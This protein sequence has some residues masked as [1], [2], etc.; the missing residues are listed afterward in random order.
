[1]K[2]ATDSVDSL[3]VNGSA[4]N[5]NS[6]HKQKTNESKI[7]K[8]DQ[9]SF[10]KQNTI[11]LSEKDQKLNHT[12]I[13]SLSAQNSLDA[14]TNSFAHR[15]ERTHSNVKNS[16]H[17]S[18]KGEH[19]KSLSL[20]WK[21]TKRRH[22]SKE[23]TK[24]LS[25]NKNDGRT[26]HK[27]VNIAS[28]NKGNSNSS[29]GRFTRDYPYLYSQYEPVSRSLYSTQE[30][31]WRRNNI[32]ESPDTYNTASYD[33][34]GTS[35]NV[36][37]VTSSDLRSRLEM[38]R[39][40][41]RNLY[42]SQMLPLPLT[43]IVR[44]QNVPH[45]NR[46]AL[47]VVN[48]MLPDSPMDTV[49]SYVSLNNGIGERI[50]N[51]HLESEQVVSD[52]L[53]KANIPTGSAMSLIQ[54]N[55]NIN[56][57]GNEELVL[58]GNAR[59]STVL[60]SSINPLER[61][62]LNPIDGST[63]AL[64]GL[65]A[66]NLAKLEN[67]ASPTRNSFE[68]NRDLSNGQLVYDSTGQPFI[69]L[70]AGT[71]GQKT[72]QEQLNLAT[73]DDLSRAEGHVNGLVGNVNS[74]SSNP[75]EAMTLIPQK[76]D[77]TSK[78]SDRIHLVGPTN[79]FTE[80]SQLS[81]NVT[82]SQDPSLTLKPN[83]SHVVGLQQ[84]S[85]LTP[86]M[87][88][89][90]S[91]TLPRPDLHLQNKHSASQGMG[92]D[93]FAS[94][95]LT[96]EPSVSSAAKLSAS[97]VHSVT[98]SSK[99][100]VQASYTDAVGISPST[101]LASLLSKTVST[102]MKESSVNQQNKLAQTETDQPFQHKVHPYSKEKEFHDNTY[103]DIPKNRNVSSDVNITASSPL[104][105]RNATSQQTSGSVD[106]PF[107]TRLVLPEPSPSSMSSL[108]GVSTNVLPT[109]SV[110][111][112]TPLTETVSFDSLT[113]EHLSK[114]ISNT[115]S[116]TLTN[117]LTAFI[118]PTP[119][120]TY[121][122]QTSTGLHDMNTGRLS[123]LAAEGEQISNTPMR[124]NNMTQYIHK[125]NGTESM[126]EEADQ[127]PTL[128]THPL[129]SAK[130]LRTTS[131]PTTRKASTKQPGN[132]GQP[133]TGDKFTQGY[134]T[135]HPTTTPFNKHN[136][137][138]QR[139]TTSTFNRHIDLHESTAFPATESTEISTVLPTAPTAQ[140]HPTS[141]QVK[142][143]GNISLLSTTQNPTVSSPSDAMETGKLNLPTVGLHNTNNLHEQS[144]IN[145]SQ[146]HLP[147]FE[148]GR[149]VFRLKYP[150]DSN[151]LGEGLDYLADSGH[152]SDSGGKFILLINIYFLLVPR[153]LLQ[154][155]LYC[156]S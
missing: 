156:F 87:L 92:K 115:E 144:K 71:G 86:A 22:R 9:K 98:T 35:I 48:D 91:S 106:I 74:P 100:P 40:R 34:L 31:D 112:T 47:S 104:H 143:V 105:N 16:R 63:E 32:L 89:V 13:K 124:N 141:P 4:Q 102:L 19:K 138:H 29:S 50:R 132:T 125:K 45:S 108:S 120:S 26:N 150:Q 146:K 56:P 95:Y 67:M 147:V 149:P 114:K 117:T 155:F 1:M 17:A 14:K 18:K 97:S 121:L 123:S 25:N 10:E 11:E 130:K 131:R 64:K 6:S 49:K 107:P 62:S 15:A 101:S 30:T 148:A 96:S 54:D 84:G 118:Q 60:R 154:R 94:S 70:D 69:D 12:E 24:S 59:G 152:Q 122:G 99:I 153:K 103:V 127:Q 66:V 46:L 81:S 68:A 85:M 27:I 134:Q 137:L 43:D 76:T 145:D 28:K 133:A 65:S 75:K 79:G 82:L 38:Q 36:P 44:R 42:T 55:S 128:T 116:I 41:D 5:V 135:R 90:H 21:H 33:D 80:Q 88:Q 23:K 2:N 72:L 53:R 93:I 52:D 126:A 51:G 37:E 109:P 83:S 78:S 3:Q 7:I 20:N 136:E 73:Q 58:P 151:A 39:L 77:I 142:A 57:T 119:P 140:L 110:T 111:L 61:T 129:H 113:A 139:P 8:S